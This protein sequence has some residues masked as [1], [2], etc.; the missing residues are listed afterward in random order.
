M[1]LACRGSCCA[2]HA[3]PLIPVIPIIVELLKQQFETDAA[4]EVEDGQFP[5]RLGGPPAI[6]LV[7]HSAFLRKIRIT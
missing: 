4:T 1:Q 7:A 5:A 2:A 3:T 6:S